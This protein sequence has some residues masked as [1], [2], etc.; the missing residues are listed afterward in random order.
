MSC[1]VSVFLLICK[2]FHANNVQ[3]LY[4]P[5]HANNNCVEKDREAL[6]NAKVLQSVCYAVIVN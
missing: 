2:F 4:V 5:F 1:K 3:I 6:N